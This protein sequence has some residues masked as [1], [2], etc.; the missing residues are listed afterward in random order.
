[1]VIRVT[2][3]MDL[4]L[5]RMAAAVS[6]AMPYSRPDSSTYSKLEVRGLEAGR[7]MKTTP[8]A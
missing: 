6:R 8:V 5:R 3:A 7:I 2:Q 4:Y 1:M